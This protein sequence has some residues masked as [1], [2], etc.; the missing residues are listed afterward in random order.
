VISLAGVTFLDALDKLITDIGLADE[1][2]SGYGVTREEIPDL[3]DNAL[4]VMT[5]LFKFTP[6]EMT[7]DD[8]IAIYEAA[9]E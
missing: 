7:R 4:T 5:R 6:V 8:V 2:L 1:T 3:A 9:Y